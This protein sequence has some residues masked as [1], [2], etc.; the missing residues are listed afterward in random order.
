MYSN[1]LAVA[2]KSAGK[3]L[4]EFGD[5]VYVPFGSEYSIL[6]KNLSS[7]RA[8]VTVSVDGE[9]VGEGTKFVVDANDSIDLERFIKNGNFN[10]GNRFKF[11]ERT[12]AVEKHR[13]VGIEDGLVRVEYQFEDPTPITTITTTQPWKPWDNTPYWYG[14]G[15]NDFKYYNAN[16]TGDLI[17]GQ[18]TFTCSASSERSLK[19]SANVN[20]VND[21]G[22]TVPGSV[23]DQQFVNA[24]W[25][26]LETE[27]HVMVLKILGETK[28]NVVVRKPVTVK[29]KPKCVT[30]GT[31]NKATA[32]FCTECGTSLTIV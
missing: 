22:V 19:G 2:L 6:I 28:D 29:T 7:V 5:Q 32:K 20:N 16:S 26:P 30:C 23:S 18:S 14:S 11:I 15:G 13:G 10:A 27:T 8:L 25:F 12:D 3:V 31:S 1:K 21:V 17:G 4:R 9:D 24:G